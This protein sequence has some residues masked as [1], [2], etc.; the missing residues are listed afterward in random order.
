MNG[1]SQC[2]RLLDSAVARLW[3]LLQWLLAEEGHRQ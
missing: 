1:L 2:S 3:L